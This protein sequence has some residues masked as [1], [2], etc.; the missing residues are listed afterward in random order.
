MSYAAGSDMVKRY[1]V[2]RLGDLVSD[3]GTRVVDPTTDPNLQAAL[4]D[5][6]GLID[7]ALLRG[8]RYQPAD[9]SG[10][11]ANSSSQALLFRINCDLAY[12]LLLQRRDLTA[13]KQVEVAYGLLDRLAE[14]SMIF[15]AVQ[16]AVNSGQPV[17]VRLDFDVSL[18]SSLDRVFGDQLVDP[19]NNSVTP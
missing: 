16:A 7:A 12:G 13:P 4:D 9:L 18:I 15:G 10:L 14:G 1:D 8:G 5:A 11:P 17:N 3:T 6:A 19:R 2:R